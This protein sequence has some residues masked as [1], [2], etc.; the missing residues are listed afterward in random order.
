MG[1]FDFFNRK[2]VAQVDYATTKSM[3]KK[4][5]N[6]VNLDEIQKEL[7]HFL[8]QLGFKKKGRTFN[9]ETEKGIYQIINIQSGQ[10]PLI[11]NYVIKGLRE[12]LYGKFTIN[13]GVCIEDLYQIQYPGQLK[14][15][16][17]DYDCPIRLRLSNL[18]LEND[19]W[20]PI[21]DPLKSANEII[22]GLT[23]KGLPWFEQFQNREKIIANWGN[24][25]WSSN[26]AKLDVALIV[27]SKDRKLG[28]EMFRKYYHAITKHQGHKESVKNLANKLGISLD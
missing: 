27:F 23:E 2:K 6:V 15:F 14:S 12:N 11:E 28:A 19:Y 22:I 5:P 8:K 9:R 13:L 10:F 17:Q 1:V 4:S 18:M 21:N 3:Q 16:Y 25:K 24:V 7:Y 26:I 20:W